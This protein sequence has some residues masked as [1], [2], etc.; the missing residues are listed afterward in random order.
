MMRVCLIRSLT[1]GTMYQS[2]QRAGFGLALLSGLGAAVAA[3]PTGVAQ[4]AWLS[5]CWRGESGE[6]G[7][8]EQWMPPAGAACWA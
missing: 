1:M 7:T 6:A 4:L 2:M 8:Q 5:G 3:E